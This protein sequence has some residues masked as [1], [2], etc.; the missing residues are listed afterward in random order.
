MSLRWGHLVLGCHDALWGALPWVWDCRSRGLRSWGLPSWASWLV[1]GALGILGGLDGA[2]WG[3]CP[4]LACGFCFAA[5]S[6][7]WCRGGFGRSVPP[8]LNV[9][10]YLILVNF[11]ITA[12]TT[13]SVPNCVL[14]KLRQHTIHLL[15]YFSFSALQLQ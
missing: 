5:G 12:D 8:I 14:S 11:K 15:N 1:Q 13:S 10:L 2:V 6:S 3:L 4:S 7:G 9:L